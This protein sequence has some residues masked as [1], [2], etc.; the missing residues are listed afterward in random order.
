MEFSARGLVLSERTVGDWDKSL[1]LL[2]EGIGKI[3]V[4]AKGAKRVKSPLL[5]A[6]ALFT[7]GSY[8]FERKGERITVESAQVEESFFGLRT[9][10]EALALAAYLCEL[11]KTLCAEQQEE[12]DLLRLTL[13]ALFALSKA[14]VP[15]EIV[16]PAF[17]LRS[18]AQS[19]F[20]PAL[21]GCLDC[22]EQQAALIF[23]ALQGGLLCERHRAAARDAVAVS[24]AVLAAM[25]YIC[26]CDAKKL[27]AFRLPKEP[28]KELTDLCE[29]YTTTMLGMELP[30]LRFYRSMAAAAPI[31]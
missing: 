23:S 4:W 22:G 31:D 2:C 11:C 20:L 15:K 29:I 25:R 24:P 3:S 7:F 1:V 9:D 27:Y 18:L 30:T 12:D 8:S 19:G 28:L 17:E 14:S 5:G 16:K 6:S 13:N 26:S 21:N 10:L